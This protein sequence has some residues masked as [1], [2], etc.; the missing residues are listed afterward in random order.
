M[1]SRMF[2]PPRIIVVGAGAGGLAFAL[3]C[4]H[5]GVRVRI[6]DK[7]PA[8]TLIQKATGVAQG[9]WN[10]LAPYG[11]TTSVIRDAFPMQ[12]FVFHDDNRLVADVP[13][14]LV[15]GKAPAHLY[16]QGE[17]EK[18]METALCA[19]GVGVE[20]ATGFVSVEQTDGVAQAT[21]SHENGEL[22]DLEV[23]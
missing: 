4:A 17:L 3:A 10:Q 15:N 6:I 12:H 13:V 19:R 14:P 2:I 22:E 7:R 9:V 5:R 16:P 8:R 20:Y 21:V 23:D 11:I 1:I 18:V